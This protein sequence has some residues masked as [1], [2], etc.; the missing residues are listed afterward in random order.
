MQE[1]GFIFEAKQR[2][3]C[4]CLGKP[5]TWSKFKI[6]SY[7]GAV[8]LFHHYHKRTESTLFHKPPPLKVYKSSEKNDDGGRFN[9][10]KHA[11]PGVKADSK[12]S[13]RVQRAKDEDTV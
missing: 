6:L 8:H 11:D 5:V 13:V 4:G 9:E 2:Y 12:R 7:L 10:I 1:Q 3:M